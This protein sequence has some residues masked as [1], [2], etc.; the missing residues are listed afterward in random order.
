M[1]ELKVQLKGEVIDGV[2]WSNLIKCRHM[3]TCQAYSGILFIYPADLWK[4]SRERQES[5]DM[6]E[7]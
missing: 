7:T 5:V 2:D 1:G 6:D 4:E 3:S